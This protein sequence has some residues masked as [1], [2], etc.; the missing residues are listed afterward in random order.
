MPHL[1]AT[2]ISPWACSLGSLKNEET[3]CHSAVYYR[4]RFIRARSHG[5]RHTQTNVDECARTRGRRCTDADSDADEHKSACVPSVGGKIVQTH[6]ALKRTFK[7][8]RDVLYISSISMFNSSVISDVEC[9]CT[10]TWFCMEYMSAHLM[11]P[12]LPTSSTHVLLQYWNLLCVIFDHCMLKCS[13]SVCYTPHTQSLEEKEKGNA[14]YKKHEFETALQHYDKALEMDPTNITFLTNKAGR[15]Y[16]VPITNA[17]MRF[18]VRCLGARDGVHTV[19]QGLL[20][21]TK[22]FAPLP[23]PHT[24]T[25]IHLCKRCILSSL[26]GSSV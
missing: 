8:L 26:S 15:C 14:A 23:P 3:Q 11:I 12:L 25:C 4:T 20:P 22:V 5:H 16:I 18:Y 19:L 17:P 13:T 21:R 9:T 10:C 2:V 6:P 7:D 24:F 1:P